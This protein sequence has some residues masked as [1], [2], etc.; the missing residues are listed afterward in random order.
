[1]V[2]ADAPRANWFVRVSDVA[3]DGT[4]TQVAGAGFNGTHRNSAR[5]PEDIEPGKEFD[6]EIEMHFTSWVFP[7]GHRIRFAV[8]NSQWPMMWPTPYPMTT[9]LRLG[10]S[11]GSHVI[12]PIVPPGE[13]RTP[14]FLPPVE[15]PRLAGFE[16]IDLGNP[17]GYGEISSVDR[18]P[19][20]GEVTAK[21]TNSGA[22][23]FPWGTQTYRETIEHKTSDDHPE[24]TSVHGTH[25]LEV[26]LP[27]RILLWE[28][29][30]DFSSDLDNFYY[31]YIRRVSENG[32]LVREK[33]W[34]RTIERDFQ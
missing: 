24:N 7:A 4:V 1:M 29:E 16:S 12:L 20:T 31:R 5:E 8:N 34:T 19:Q 2:A 32:E 10:G 33:E 22:T 21:A 17:S 13:E 26:T 27:G 3:P 23:K 14:S 28:A 30:L 6:L 9:T 18:N 15:N 25:R 11:S